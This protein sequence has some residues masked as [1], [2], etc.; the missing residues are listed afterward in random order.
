MHPRLRNLLL[1]DSIYISS[2]ITFQNLAPLSSYLGKPGNPD[3]GGLTFSEYRR[4]QSQHR[5]SPL[6]CMSANC[7]CDPMGDIMAGIVR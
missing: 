6:A 1:T 4:R 5:L 7:L 2:N 3:R